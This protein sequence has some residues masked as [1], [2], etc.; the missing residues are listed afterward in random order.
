MADM[1]YTVT[2][3]TTKAVSNINLLSAGIK[4]AVAAFGTKQIADF[5]KQIINATSELQTYSNRLRLVT[6]DT[7]DLERLTS[8]LRQTAV[9]TRTSFGDTV[10]LFSKLRV[11]TEQLGVAEERVIE[12]TSK[13]SKALQVAGADGNTASSVI[14]QFGQAMASG[15]VRGDEFRSIVEGLGPAL[16]IMARESGLGVGELRKMSRE[17]KLSAQVMFEMFENSKLLSSAF[18][19]MLP[20]IDQLETQLSDAFTQALAK[21]GEL[22]GV[23]SAY[24]TLI[25]ELTISFN[26]FAGNETIRDLPLTEILKQAEDGAISLTDALNEVN[27]RYLELLDMGPMDLLLSPINTIKGVLS[28][29][30]KNSRE[31]AKRVLE[32]LKKIEEQQKKDAAAV[33]QQN[34]EYA[35]LKQQIADLYK[36]S[37]IDK[38]IT[39][40]NELEGS[41]TFEKLGT[42]LDQYRD[43][44]KKAQETLEGLQK[45][46]KLLAEQGLDKDSLGKV[47]DEYTKISNAVE[48]MQKYIKDLNREIEESDGVTT[49]TEY[50]KDLMEEVRTAE[51]K[52]ENGRK[53]L[54][55]LEEELAKGTITTEQYAIALEKVK[56]E[57]QK[58][59]TEF[60][61]AK[62]KADSFIADLGYGTRE[63]QFEFDK[64][65]MNPLERQIERIKIAMDRD[66]QRTIAEIERARTDT[67]SAK[68]DDEIARVSKASEDA[69]KKQVE[70][71]KKIR[72]QQR[73]FS[74]GWR[75]AF[76]EYVEA[77]TDAGKQAEAIFRKTTQ[78]MEDAIVDFAKTGKFEWKSFVSSIVEELLRAQVRELIANTFSGIG[79]GTASARSGGKS[80]LLGLGG[81]FGFLANGGPAIANRPYIVGERGPEVFVPNSTGTV[82]PNDKI[83]GTTQITY[84]IN[85]VDALSFKQM[86]ARDPSFIYAVSQQGAKAIPG[87]R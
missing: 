58:V 51:D 18:S 7:A 56:E 69:F 40:F 68:I 48:D 52:T 46:Q 62:S 42:P 87:R 26:Q 35:K 41:K 4:T 53:A 81:M 28:G 54:Q 32:E 65:N 43:K 86:I 75:R 49:F 80:G 29:E 25:K 83:G 72:E 23:T 8:I 64:L 73:S 67:N 6:K 11:S 2:V 31:E 16:A 61:R 30:F 13:L 57:L 59:D 74:Y 5:G 82:V 70:L 39:A 19:Q 77:A 21:L 79:L 47:S 66:L 20:T 44:L 63:A 84:N 38:F 22:T 37:G 10:D 17:G 14:R 50:W 71:T 76:D 27:K 24:N 45:A 85:A 60:N 1:K 9:D 3:D 15:E 34:E 12:V 36:T 33:A 78:G 55:R